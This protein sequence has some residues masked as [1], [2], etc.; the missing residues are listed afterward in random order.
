MLIVDITKMVAFPKSP[1]FYGAIALLLNPE[2][3]VRYQFPVCL[4]N[5]NSWDTHIAR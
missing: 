4:I 2:G 3:P 5:V 1:P